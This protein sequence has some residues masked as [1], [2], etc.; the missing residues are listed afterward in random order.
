VAPDSKSEL[1]GAISASACKIT[2][3]EAMITLKGTST[4]TSLTI[5]LNTYKN[6]ISTLGT[7]DYEILVYQSAAK[8]ASEDPLDS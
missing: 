8:E 7:E 2:T 5:T 3:S 6:P 4:D 1:S